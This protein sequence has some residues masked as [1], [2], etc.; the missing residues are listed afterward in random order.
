MHEE[1]EAELSAL[2][3][4][5]QEQQRVDK[6]PRGEGAAAST[7]EREGKTTHRKQQENKEDH[8]VGIKFKTAVRDRDNP[9]GAHPV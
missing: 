9:G 4:L 3:V 8:I 1:L 6:D 5:Q 7:R 2:P